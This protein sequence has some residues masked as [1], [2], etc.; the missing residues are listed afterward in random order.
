MD[1][2]SLVILE[3]FLLDHHEYQDWERLWAPTGRYFVPGGYDPDS[4]ALIDDD[5]GALKV[6]LAQLQHPQ[7]YGT[8]P[9][10]ETARVITPVQVSETE[11]GGEVISSFV[12]VHSHGATQSTWAGRLHH[13]WS[14]VNGEVLLLEKRVLLIGRDAPLETLGFIL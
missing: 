11:E 1:L 14:F 8:Q 3:G 4:L 13:T 12:L 6:R 2:G 9:R 5:M 10:S 7:H